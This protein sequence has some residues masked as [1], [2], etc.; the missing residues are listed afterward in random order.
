M[1]MKEIDRLQDKINQ[2]IKRVKELEA[3]KE[4]ATQRV[5]E[6]AKEARTLRAERDQVINE[7]NTQIIAT[8]QLSKL[9]DSLRAE[10]E[11]LLA[12]N[13]SLKRKYIQVSLEALGGG[14]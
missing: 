5:I 3:C 4:E 6:H 1:D 9:I 11:R 7:R 13:E 12:E 8:A 10:V 2:L 14:A